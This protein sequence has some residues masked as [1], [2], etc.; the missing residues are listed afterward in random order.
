MRSSRL[1]PRSTPRPFSSLSLI[2]TSSSPMGILFFFSLFFFLLLFQRSFFF[3]LRIETSNVFHETLDLRTI[4]RSFDGR[5]I[6]SRWSLLLER[7]N[8]G[9]MLLVF[10][11]TASR[12]VDAQAT[13]DRRRSRRTVSPRDARL[14]LRPEVNESNRTDRARTIE[15]IY[16]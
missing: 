3:F 6:E 8:D 15:C 9:P 14:Y 2:S 1:Y 5:S 12:R 13:P 11:R 10:R 16:K 4:A 7:R